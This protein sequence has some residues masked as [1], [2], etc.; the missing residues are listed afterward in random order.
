[1]RLAN[2]VAIIT[3]A[4]SGIGRASAM[5]FAKEGA[6]VVVADIDDKGGNETVVAIHRVAGDAAVFVHTDVSVASEA[7][8]LIET[9]MDS[10]GK[11]DILFNNAGISQKSIP[12]ENLDESLW[13]RIYSVNVKG[14]YLTIKYTAPIMKKA[15]S[16]VIINLASISG[17]RPRMEQSAY[18]SSKAAVIHLTKALALELAQYRI[19]VNAINPVAVETP[20]LFQ[21]MPEDAD[22]EEFKEGLLKT[23]PLGR[24]AT[25]DDVAHGALYLASDEASIITGTCLNVDGGRGI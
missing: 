3:G 18:A 15:Q 9:A 4:G 22:K 24:M 5:L 2:K 8:N 6:R 19:R 20:M 1:M 13:D 7:E 14:T 17:V 21:I 16:G 23:I 10:Y 12:V 25:P 11:I